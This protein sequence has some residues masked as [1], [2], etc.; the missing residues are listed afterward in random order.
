MKKIWTYGLSFGLLLLT[1]TVQSQTAVDTIYQNILQANAIDPSIAPEIKIATSKRFGAAYQPSSN[2]ILVENHLLQALNQFGAAKKDALAFLIGH[3][4]IHALQQL[5]HDEH[6]IAYD[7]TPNQ[8]RSKE[9]RADIQGAFMAHLAGYEC[10]PVLPKLI[11]AI[12]E[13]YELKDQLAGYPSKSERQYTIWKVVDQ[14][15]KLQYMYELANLLTLGGEESMGIDL[16]SEILSFVPSPILEYNIGVGYIRTALKS[17]S[18][19]VD[20]F[21]L[22]VELDW[23]LRLDLPELPGG[24]KD[25]PIGERYRRDINL[26]KASIHFQ[27]SLE[28][29]PEYTNGI[30]GW[31]MVKL[32]EE[33]FTESQGILIK[34]LQSENLPGKDK[35]L[36]LLILGINHLAIGTVSNANQCFNQISDPAFAYY[37]KLNDQIARKEKTESQKAFT[38]K[39]DLTSKFLSSPTELRFKVE[40]GLVEVS[41]QDY[42]VTTTSGC[43]FDFIRIDPPK[44][45]ITPFHEVKQVL[46]EHLQYLSYFEPNSRR[47]ISYSFS[48][49]PCASPSR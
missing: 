42:R 44:Y 31:S 22:P 37:A 11:D 24:A 33:K 25:L 6:F 13:I 8:E 1:W 17:C 7:K 23:S 29:N 48:F 16:Y 47:W 35:D 26:K 10:G 20:Q 3:E 4:L 34:T 21:V 15:N 27:N 46:G 38:G 36:L 14:V 19:Q 9:E 32:L 45:Q 30:A 18:Y 41:G 43:Q 49:T 5:D 28:L 39:I 12:Y 40:H 2:T